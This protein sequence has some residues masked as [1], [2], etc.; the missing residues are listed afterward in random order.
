MFN[1][2]MTR[3]VGNVVTAAAVPPT[4]TVY[5]TGSGSYTSPVGCSY[6]IVEMCGAGGGGAQNSNTVAPQGGGGGAYVKARYAPGTYSYAVGAAG[7]GS[8]GAG[9][10]SAGGATTFGS[11][12][13]LGG[14]GGTIGQTGPTTSAGYVT[15][16][17][18]LLILGI[19]GG[20][21]SNAIS[22][23][24]SPGGTSFW[25]NATWFYQGPNTQS[26]QP[27]SF[28]YGGGGG[29]ITTTNY[30]TTTAGDGDSG[31]IFITEY[32]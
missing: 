7:A 32:Y 10:G 29:G 22:N 24:V 21:G 20:R 30:S 31:R 16:G 6:I 4:Y 8:A 14:A 28:G 11:S 25:S 17:M 18:S 26:V 12:S 2:Y 5:T 23:S 27:T 13:A 1:R 15:T 3:S 9:S 19:Q